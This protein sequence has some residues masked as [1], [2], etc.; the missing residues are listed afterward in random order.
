M[1]EAEGAEDVAGL[2]WFR[3]YTE[4]VD[5]PKMARLTGGEFRTWIYLLA[6][7]RQAE[8]PGVVYMGIPALAWRLRLTEDQLRSDLA[9]L[10]REGMV[11]LKEAGAVRVVKFIERQYG[12][13]SDW[14]DATRDRK[15]RSRDIARRSRDGHATDSDIDSDTDS[16]SEESTPLAGAATK[17][18]S[19]AK[20]S[21]D[22]RVKQF[23]DYYFVALKDRRGLAAFPQFAKHGAMV[24]RWLAALDATDPDADALAAL[25]DRLDCYLTLDDAFL[26]ANGWSLDVFATRLQGLAK[27][28]GA[29]VDW[30]KEP[31]YC[32]DGAA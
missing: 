26:R 32:G 6:L 23:L 13:P 11:D 8:E 27:K 2:P 4:I 29:E 15:R 31:G 7:A 16:D 20:K 12:K 25:I 3:V 1:M 5:D 30:T 21:P 18:T 22:P 17:R 10:E 9:T 28:G 24:K 19:R 14:P